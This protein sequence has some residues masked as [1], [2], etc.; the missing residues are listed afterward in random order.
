MTRIIVTASM[1]L[2]AGVAWSQS[3]SLS[4]RWNG[5]IA[6]PGSV[7]QVIV[8]LDDS[9]S[10]GTIDIPA[11]NAR[12]LKLVRIKSTGTTIDFSIDGIPGDPTFHGNVSP[13]G[14]TI[15]G[16]FV[17]G[18]ATMPFTLARKGLRDVERD[19]DSLTA[20]LRDIRAAV[21]DAMTRLKA[22][23]VAVAIVVD[24]SVVMAEGFGVAD[25]QTG[26]AVTP[27]TLFMIGSSTKAFTATLVALLV[28]DGRLDWD[29]KVVEHLHDF[30]LYDSYATEHIAVIDLLTHVS[31]L[32]R[33]D[34]LWYGSG[35]SRR[36]LYDRLRYLEPSADLRE[37]WQYQNLMFMTAGILVERSLGDSWEN[38]LR[39]RI[40]EPLDMRGSGA[41]LAEMEASADHAVGY[42]MKRKEEEL[43]T[44]V[45][46]YR[47]IDDVGPA[48]SIVSN[49]RDMAAWLRFNLGDGRVEG[50]RFVSA[51]T[52]QTLHAPRVVV[53][54]AG[55]SE[56]ETL[57]SLYAP[58][59]SV[60][61]YR[62][63]RLV[64]H[65]GNIDGF[66]AMVSMLPDR[67]LGV[68]VLTNVNGSSLPMALSR[69]IFDRFINAA[70]KDWVASAEQMASRTREI[71]ESRTVTGFAA[72]RVPDTEPSHALKDYVGS[73]NH[74]AY[75]TIEVSLVNG[76][77]HIRNNLL[78]G[79]LLHYHYEF[80]SIGTDLEEASG[81]LVE[82]KTGTGGRIESLEIPLEPSVAPISFDRAAS[83]WMSTPE[84]LGRYAGTFELS[85][86]SITFHVD[87]TSLVMS[88]AGD[89]T[90]R[91]EPAYD[92]EFRLKGVGGYSVR[93]I[94]EDGAA[95]AAVL[96]QPD[97]MYRATRK[98]DQ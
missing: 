85:G 61:A 41:T 64:E 42:V 56:T 32:P 67:R 71:I 40:F 88:I 89:R 97:G 53:D 93:F 4:G 63:E 60:A 58:G 9:C 68:V 33:H 31:G 74:S 51:A 22:P 44:E 50:K 26:R 11:Q 90:Y 75:G 43:K 45:I 65:G 25:M 10:S 23:G 27:S 21:T 28:D 69:V 7:L 5:S 81:M 73:Y 47:N 48:G 46:P 55:S 86:Y 70:T 77:L 79:E 95:V 98:D 80:F 35:L 91:L 3:V 19:Q 29:D 84:G 36:D 76:T 94:M 6:T 83:A 30:R 15:S 18:G 14:D 37:K 24:D 1:L 54:G 52:L 8:H 34:A 62:G 72:V 2:V 49:A 17:Q 12:G 16:D 20:R 39:K 13:G 92:D 38:V 66:T 96:I 82:F 57:F 87:S 78:Q 59:W